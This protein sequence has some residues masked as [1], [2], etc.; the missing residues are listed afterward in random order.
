MQILQ[1]NLILL[2]LVGIGVHRQ[3]AEKDRL[4]IR[5]M[6]GF[7]IMGPLSLLVPSF[8]SFLVNIEDVVNATEGLYMSGVLTM[9]LSMQIFYS[10][11]RVDVQ[12]ILRELQIIVSSSTLNVCDFAFLFWF[13]CFCCSFHRVDRWQCA[14]LFRY[15]THGSHYMEIDFDILYGRGYIVG[16]D[17]ISSCIL[18]LSN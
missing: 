15:G 3:H 13:L 16:V 7:C 2:R 6:N 10:L 18:F 11:H 1:K 8:A 14:N 17:A 5:L 12:I 9:I 4:S